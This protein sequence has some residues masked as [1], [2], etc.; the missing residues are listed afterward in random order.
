MYMYIVNKYI[1]IFRC[2]HIFMDP[3]TRIDDC[4]VTM[5]CRLICVLDIT[6]SHEKLS[7]THH[8]SREII[9]TNLPMSLDVT[10]V[11]M[12]CRRAYMRV[13]THVIPT[14]FTFFTATHTATHTATRTAT[15]FAIY[16]HDS[17]IMYI[18]HCNTHCNTHCYIYT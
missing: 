17:Y 14:S 9:I 4:R 18:L 10:L 3:M 2:I 8:D 13:Y 6:N 15:Q 5:N 1:Y 7:R 16:T 11:T 12:K